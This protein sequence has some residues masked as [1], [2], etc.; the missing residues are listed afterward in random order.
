MRPSTSSRVAARRSQY[1][2]IPHTGYTLPQAV[3]DAKRSGGCT[4]MI[5]PTH[6]M[7]SPP[8]PRPNVDAAT[9]HGFGDEWSR[10][11]Q[12][13]LTAE[14]HA[15][16]FEQYFGI[17]PWDAL[18]PGAAGMDV[19]CGSGRWARG[20]APRVGHLHLVDAS[21]EALAVA[22]QALASCQT[23]EFHL[24]SAG[25][26]P[27][28]DASLDFGYSLGVLHHVPDTA[29]ALRECARCLRPGAPFLVYLYYAFDN[30]PA[31]FRAVWRSSDLLR[32]AV[33]RLPMPLRYAVSQV[34]AGAV[35]WPLATASRTGT[36]AGLDTTNWPL[37]YY[38]DRSFYTMRTDALDR[39]GTRLE[40]RFT[41]AQIAALL[42]EAGFDDVRF[43][44]GVPYWCAVARKRRLR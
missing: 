29:A 6:R 36:R 8:P 43:S 32:R 37:H 38:A 40:Q 4:T 20:V 3:S 42:Q 19:G 7:S 2:V 27:F 10:F 15:E 14:E 11:D 24:A 39:F 22:R 18:P 33:S 16:L 30:R 9:V 21:P 17:F 44:D 13:A 23:C 1:P 26:L 41:R 25:R 31:W 28:G 5:V 34:I 12:T 35:Y